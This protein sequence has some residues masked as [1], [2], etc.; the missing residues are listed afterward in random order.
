MGW[1]IK[2]G[3]GF[4]ADLTQATAAVGDKN[5]ADECETAL[6]MRRMWTI[7]LV[8][9]GSVA[10]L[11]LLVAAATTSARESLVPNRDTA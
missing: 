8:V 1:Q 5:F 2:C 6:L 7:P 9:F 11:W 10:L 4:T 3:R